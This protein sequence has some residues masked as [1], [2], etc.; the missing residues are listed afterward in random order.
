MPGN[1]RYGYDIIADELK[2]LVEK[3]GPKLKSVMLFG[4]MD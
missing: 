4:V 1:Y 3:E 2:P